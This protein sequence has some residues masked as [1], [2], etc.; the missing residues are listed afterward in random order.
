MPTRM[1][2][3]YQ[4]SS[5]HHSHMQQSDNYTLTGSNTTSTYKHNG[6]HHRGNSIPLWLPCY[7]MVRELQSMHTDLKTVCMQCVQNISVE[8]FTTGHYYDTCVVSLW[9]SQRDIRYTFVY[10]TSHVRHLLCMQTCVYFTCS[11]LHISI[12]LL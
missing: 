5:E 3:Q 4:I 12:A 8:Y 7:L 9:Q 11:S 2:P 1:K 10:H 6:N